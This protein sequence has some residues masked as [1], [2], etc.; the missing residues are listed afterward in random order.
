MK[1]TLWFFLA[2]MLVAPGAWA[3]TKT[4]LDT[5]LVASYQNGSAVTWQ[6]EFW[7]E[8]IGEPGGGTPFKPGFD[9]SK[10]EVTWTGPDV[11]LKFFTNYPESGLVVGGINAKVADLFLDLDEN[12]IFEAGVKMSGAD[13]GKFYSTISGVANSAAYFDSTGL[14]YGDKFN[15]DNPTGSP[16]YILSSVA[17]PVVGTLDWTGTGPYEVIIDL[18]GVNSGGDWNTFGFFWGVAQCSNDG[19]AG[20]AAPIPGSLLLLGSGILGLV[21]IGRRRKT[22]A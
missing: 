3:T 16:V 1:K 15:K 4:I 20:T 14:I 22:S 19:F 13:K 21:G 7:H 11:Q 17:T 5:T 8:V 9:V 2:L 12:G 18:P 6:G 10:L